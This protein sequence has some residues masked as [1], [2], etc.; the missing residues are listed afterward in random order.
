MW[1]F[2]QEP[3]FSLKGAKWF[4]MAAWA[5]LL[6]EVLT[7]SLRHRVDWHSLAILLSLVAVAHYR[8]W[9]AR[10]RQRYSQSSQK[11]SEALG[12]QRDSS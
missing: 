7:A 9:R 2:F 6:M 10:D 12:N 11:M 4:V 1:N 8:Y 5:L 3:K